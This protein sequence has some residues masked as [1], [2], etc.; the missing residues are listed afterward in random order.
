MDRR[1][2]GPLP[3]RLVA[4][5]SHPSRPAH[6]DSG[7][8]TNEHI[9]LIAPDALHYVYYGCR[10]VHFLEEL[11][12]Q[13]TKPAVT[14]REGYPMMPARQ[15]PE[16]IPW[17]PDGQP[18]DHSLLWRSRAGDQDAAT[19]LYLRYAER[20]I[21]LVRRQCSADLA[22]W[23]GVE[24]IVQSVFISF[25][26]R[27]AQGYYDVPDGEELWKLLLVIALHKIRGKA[28]YYSAAKRNAHRT[29][30]GE[31][32]Q[33]RLDSQVNA[34]E[35]RHAD[36]ELALNDALE[37]LPL[38]SRVMVK[39]RIE[40]CQVAEISRKTGRSRRSVERILQETR[41]RLDELLRE[42]D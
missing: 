39:L 36:L 11:A 19:Q 28:T 18:S 1:R 10:G 9:E 24:D 12:S 33:R 20:L 42:E 40:G 13:D 31:A 15:T 35:T 29:I 14:G 37:R 7:G 21:C 34:K 16:E 32:A 6:R 2:R 5:D 25:F 17:S 23:A 38:Q 3:G 41:L 22:R 30:D 4:R 27:V 8:G 26:R